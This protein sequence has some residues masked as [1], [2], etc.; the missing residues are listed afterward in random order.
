LSR[1]YRKNTWSVKDLPINKKGSINLYIA[2][3]I[4][5]ELRLRTYA[6]NS[7]QGEDLSILA[8]YESKLK[9]FSDNK[10][11]Q[12]VF[13]LNDVRILYRYFYTSLA[14]AHVVITTNSYA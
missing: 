12:E 5:T 11:L 9:E 4:S 14:L 7:S 10:A 3:A 8:R 2:L 6:S 1:K 13:Y